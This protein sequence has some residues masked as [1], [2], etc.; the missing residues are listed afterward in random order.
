[1]VEA[2]PTDTRDEFRRA[3]IAYADSFEA[4][5]EVRVPREYLLILG[6]RR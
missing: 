2:L 3:Y 5:G 6:R 1:M 4:G